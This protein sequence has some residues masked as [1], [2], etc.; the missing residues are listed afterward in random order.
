MK[1]YHFTTPERAIDILKAGWFV[2]H[3][4][5]F[6][7]EMTN[8]KPCVWF[9]TGPV[10]NQV[11][12]ATV[13]YLPEHPFHEG[14]AET[15]KNYEGGRS[16][17]YGV[18]ESGCVRFEL[19]VPGHRLTHWQTWA[20]KREAV[21]AAIRMESPMPGMETWWIAFKPV[22]LSADLDL[23]V[24]A[25]DTDKITAMLREANMIEDAA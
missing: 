21:A 1:L 3:I 19:D 9:T 10:G 20:R 18:G 17:T 11:N 12:E 4:R 16:L 8:G 5:D 24:I 13:A 25:G 14:C 22:R 2:P 23:K 15:L 7:G 6:H